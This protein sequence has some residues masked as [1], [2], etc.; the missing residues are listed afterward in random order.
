MNGLP[1]ASRAS[2]VFLSTTTWGIRV[3]MRTTAILTNLP[4]EK[5]R[6]LY[7]LSRLPPS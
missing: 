3:T 2:R 5:Q 6:G 1:L 7:G 4:R